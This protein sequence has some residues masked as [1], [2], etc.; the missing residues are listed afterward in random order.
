[1]ELLEDKS[2]KMKCRFTRHARQR[3]KQ[4]FKIKKK[5]PIYSNEL[6]HL[7]TVA[8]KKQVFWIKDTNMIIVRD[9][10][11]KALLT[12]LTTDIWNNQ[13]Y[14]QA[15]RKSICQTLNN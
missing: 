4:R 3:L 7:C 5:I 10:I 14:R 2:S 11:N 12:V 6:V 8:K 9:K 13:Q 1:M 15:W